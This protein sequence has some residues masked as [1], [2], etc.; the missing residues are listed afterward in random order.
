MI[1][2]NDKCSIQFEKGLGIIEDEN[3]YCSE[4][5]A[6][7]C[8]YRMMLR[9]NTEEQSYEESESEYDEDDEYDPMKDF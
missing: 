1:C 5:C 8:E 2:Y 6:N 4:D 9:S 7:L 3:W